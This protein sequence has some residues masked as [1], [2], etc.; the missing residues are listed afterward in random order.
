MLSVRQTGVGMIEARGIHP[1]EAAE[2][3]FMVDVAISGDFGT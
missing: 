1:I 3:V 2:P